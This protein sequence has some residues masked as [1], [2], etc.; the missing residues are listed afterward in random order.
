MLLLRHKYP[1]YHAPRFDHHRRLNLLHTILN[2]IMHYLPYP[3]LKFSISILSGTL[4][5]PV[6]DHRYLLEGFGDYMEK[7]TLGPRQAGFN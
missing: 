5:Y 2:I 1:Y 7:S 3:S 6:R 4:V